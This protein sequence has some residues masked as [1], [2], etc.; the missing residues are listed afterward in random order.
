MNAPGVHWLW[1]L[2]LVRRVDRDSAAR[3]SD[4]GLEV[5]KA[6][7]ASWSARIRIRS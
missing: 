3:G 4:Q 2:S 6:S 7:M 5:V 1:D